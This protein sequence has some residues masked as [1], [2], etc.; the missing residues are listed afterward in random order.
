MNN[1]FQEMFGD[2]LNAYKNTSKYK[3]D[4]V[5]DIALRKK[6]F[7]QNLDEMWQIYRNGCVQQIVEYQ[8]GLKQIK[9]SGYKVYRNSDG[10]HKIVLQQKV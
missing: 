9:E 6:K 2:Y 3:D 7:E 8:K 10:K 5:L 4:C 1:A